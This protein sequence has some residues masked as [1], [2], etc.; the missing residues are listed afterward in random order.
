MKQLSQEKL[1]D[2]IKV[3]RD[4]LKLTQDDLSKKTGINRAMIGR[5]ERMDYIPSVQQLEKLADILKFDLDELFV[6]D[7]PA[8]YTAFRGSSLTDEEKDGIDHL[9][10]MM[11][12]AK[13]QLLL[14]K[15]L[16]NEE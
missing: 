4:S 9:F 2:F 1:A 6:E 15:A 10:S 13:Q 5:I 8:V 12:V 3:R 7:K 16:Q 11:L 14:R